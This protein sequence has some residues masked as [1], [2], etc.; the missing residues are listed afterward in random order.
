MSIPTISMLFKEN[1]VARLKWFGSG[2]RLVFSVVQL[3]RSPV[4]SSPQPSQ[5]TG[6][7]IT[8]L[9]APGSDMILGIVLLTSTCPLKAQ[10]QLPQFEISGIR[11][12]AEAKEDVYDGLR[13]DV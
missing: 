13:V 2:L 5:A 12:V 4:E 9:V 6:K 10:R 1:Q 8:A 11:N 7:A 3:W